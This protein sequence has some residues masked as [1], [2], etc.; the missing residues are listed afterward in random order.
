MKFRYSY[1]K[2]GVIEVRTIE[3]RTIEVR[4]IEDVLYQV[5]EKKTIGEAYDVIRGDNQL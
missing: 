4:T 1:K 2:I 3:V 5:N